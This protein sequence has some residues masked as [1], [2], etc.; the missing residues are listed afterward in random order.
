MPKDLI[1][2]VS[3]EALASL[4]RRIDAEHE[5][6]QTAAC[7]TI[8]HA[9]ECGRLLVEAKASVPHGEW[10]PWLRENTKVSERTARRWMRFAENSETLPAKPAT[11]AELRS[12]EEQT[13]IRSRSAVWRAAPR[14]PDALQAS[15]LCDLFHRRFG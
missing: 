12:C 1:T 13:R 5:A 2:D 8:E 9:I 10:L 6:T 14:G 4:A 15:P 11:V 7:M 3:P